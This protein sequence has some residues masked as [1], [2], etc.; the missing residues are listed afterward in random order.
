[1]ENKPKINTRVD[2]KTK[3]DGHILIT[4]FYFI[5]GYIFK[6]NF[7]LTNSSLMDIICMY[8]V[9]VQL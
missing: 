1:L 5:I 7:V 8:S 4:R 6:N 9:V 2:L 3:F